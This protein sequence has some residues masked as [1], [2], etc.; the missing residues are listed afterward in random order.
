V[1]FKLHHSI[2]FKASKW[3]FIKIF[4]SIAGFLSI[5]SSFAS[6]DS[7]KI[8]A[9]SPALKQFEEAQT[10]AGYELV[11]IH[12]KSSPKRFVLTVSKNGEEKIK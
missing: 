8:A 9:N 3:I 12:G 7:L 2:A 5:S 1:R 4:A 10:Q 11:S 6:L